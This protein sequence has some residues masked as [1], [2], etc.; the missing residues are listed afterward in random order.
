MNEMIL[1]KKY[2]VT[3]LRSN[4]YRHFHWKFAICDGDRVIITTENWKWNKRGYIVEFESKKIADFL[5]SVLDHDR[6]YSTH[7]KKF[8]EVKSKIKTLKHG[9]RI[10]FESKVAVFV[11]PDCN[12]IFQ[13]IESAKRRVLI[14]APYMDF[15]WFGN[16]KPLLNAIVNASKR[17][18]VRIILSDEATKQMLDELAE[19]EG[20]NLKAR[21]MKGLHGKLIIVDDTAIV[22]SANLNK[23]GLKLNR[24]VGVIIYSKDVA[25]FLA[26]KFDED[27]SAE[28]KDYTAY[29][30]ASVI[31]LMLAIALTHYFINRYR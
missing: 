27:W 14:Q 29:L 19:I 25:D 1:S 17:A 31:L 15:E 23:Y 24:E 18:E 26:D 20:L 12:P 16:D 22:T 2:N 21:T 6:I 30:I 3:F 13:E 9:E 28:R 7:V 5:K 8:G 11:L 10:N 4:S